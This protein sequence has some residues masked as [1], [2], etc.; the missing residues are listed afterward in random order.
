VEFA[1]VDFD[2]SEELVKSVL[3]A[4]RFPTRGWDAHGYIKRGPSIN[5]PGIPLRCW[6]SFSEY[7]LGNVLEY[8]WQ[9]VSDTNAIECYRQSIDTICVRWCGEGEGDTTGHMSVSWF[10]ITISPVAPPR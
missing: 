1:T 8:V 7:F 4:A 2:R 3:V 10:W 9:G 5:I 6:N